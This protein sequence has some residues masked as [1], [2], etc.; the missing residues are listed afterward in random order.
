MVLTVVHQYAPD[1][2]AAI[3]PRLP[4]GV[5][6]TA[7]GETADTGWSV[8]AD[9]DVL[10][11]SQNSAAVGLGRNMARPTGWPFNL[12]WVH[13]RSTGIDKYPDW[14]YEAPLLT[15]S[16]GIYAVPISEY[17]LA[18]MLSFAKGMP[19]LWATERAEWH[20]RK[21]GGL[22]GATLGIVGFGAIGKAI[23]TR[24]LAFD[25]TVL[26][27]R[28]SGGDSGME[29]VAIAPLAEV[30]ARADHLVLCA[31]LTEETRGMIDAKAMAAMKPGAHIVN[32]G[33]GPVLDTQALLPALQWLGGATLDVT[34]PEP[35]PEGHWLYG[36]PKVR[37]SPHV[38]G[39]SPQT[40]AVVT[41]LFL[42]NLRRFMA[43]ES[44][45]GVVDRAARY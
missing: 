43:G 12:K 23:A 21:L 2:A 33:R 19:G 34:D 26:G 3:A 10:L 11:I 38:S 15:V 24:A 30:L 13:L 4:Q 28:R 22:A 25:M 14:I 32:I 27:T 9:A 17:V 42:D 18:A 40:E 5:A 29:G 39:S 36:H 1:L 41:D 37:L 35:P 8:P 44:L 16:R 7:L 45:D 6:F 20:S 31:P